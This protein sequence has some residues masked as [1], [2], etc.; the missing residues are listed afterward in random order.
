MNTSQFVRW[1]GVAAIVTGIGNVIISLGVGASAPWIYIVTNVATLIALIG[2]YLFQKDSAGVMGLIAFLVA[3]AATLLL[4]FAFNLSLSAM[5]YAIG[6]V[7]IAIATLR[8]GVFPKWVPWIWLAATIVGIPG[9]FLPDLE[10]TFFLL[11]SIL[12]GAGFIGAGLTLWK[13][14]LRE[15]SVEVGGRL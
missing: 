8:A 2:I 4:T 7:L 15:V 9:V 6:L 10:Q 14:S 13:S 5:A 3:S 1:S 12:F 11:G